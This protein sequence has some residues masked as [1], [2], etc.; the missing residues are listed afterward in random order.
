MVQSEN[1]T[2][3]LLSPSNAHR[4][5]NPRQPSDLVATALRILFLNY[6]LFYFKN[7]FGGCVE[8][9]QQRG[10][11]YIFDLFSLFV[12]RLRHTR[13]RRDHFKDG[14]RH[15]KHKKR[16]FSSYF[17]SNFNLVSFIQLSPKLRR[18]VI[19]PQNMGA[20]NKT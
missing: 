18:V 16:L 9:Q 8:G 1:W 7:N 5:S 10:E 14:I 11:N 2:F 12:F 20:S 17:K 3:S 13:L 19:S 4:D 15:H 6:F